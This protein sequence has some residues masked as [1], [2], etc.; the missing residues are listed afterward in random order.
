MTDRRYPKKRRK[1]ITAGKRQDK[2]IIKAI[3]AIL[4]LICAVLF[5]IYAA[6]LLFRFF[7]GSDFGGF[8][9]EK[10]ATSSFISEI[11]EDE[12]RKDNVKYEASAPGNINGASGSDKAHE[13]FEPGKTYGDSGTD[14]IYDGFE[15]GENIQRLR[16]EPRLKDARLLFGG[17]AYLSSYVLSSYDSSG[18]IS[19]NLCENYRELIERSDFFIVNEEFPMS[20]RGSAE[21]DKEFTFRVSP[22]RVNILK[23]MGVDAVTL[24][25]N[26]VL[27][28][29]RD[30]LEDTIAALNGAGIAHTGA[31]ENTEEASKAVIWEKDG[32]RIAVLGATRVMPFSDWAAGKQSAG[33]FPAYDAYKSKLLNKI[34]E[35]SETCDYVIVY[36]HWGTEKKE[37]PDTYMRELAK[38]LV[39]S[40]ADLI[41][42][43]HP[44]VLQGTEYVGGVPVVYSLGNFLFGSSIPRTM[45]L[46]VKWYPDTGRSE[47]KL[48]PGSSASGYTKSITDSAQ[49]QEFFNYY[50][51]MSYGI[52]IDEDGNIRPD[53]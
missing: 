41:V 1:R 29:G 32:R 36:I 18:G 15:P 24:A 39:S 9:T 38:E 5:V 52:S 31:G 47:L 49:R 26:H 37:E 48:Y 30:A 21:D 40:G 19:G 2:R 34:E 12:M 16:D 35:L 10:T 28:F 45:L 43:A 8:F 33:V 6:M 11:Y 50:E 25:N 51:N 53:S 44:H 22:E 46:E 20:E 4:Y 7:I 14:N 42:G 23:E 27:D 13:S 3:S 17:N